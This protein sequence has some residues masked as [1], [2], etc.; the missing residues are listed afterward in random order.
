MEVLGLAVVLLASLVVHE[1][2]HARVALAEGDPTARDLGRVTLNPVAHIDPIGTLL[3]PGMLLA[4]GANFLFGWA[5]PVPVDPRFYRN[6]AV[7]DIKVSLAGVTANLLLALL[8]TIVVAGLV[9][10][11]RAVP[12]AEGFALAAADVGLLAIRINYI[13]MIFNLIPIPPLDG[14]HLLRHLLPA[15]LRN[16]YQR[17]GPIIALVFLGLMITGALG[18]LLTPAFLLEE[19][20]LKL[21]RWWT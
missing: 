18:V 13:L 5:K 11:A 10:L 2:A 21:I 1:Y 15:G 7:S 19:L 9:K 14:S 17:A 12:A 16:A 8:A 20:S 4:S 6:G 3:L